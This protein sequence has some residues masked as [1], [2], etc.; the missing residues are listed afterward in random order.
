MVESQELFLKLR[1]EREGG[2]GNVVSVIKHIA[3]QSG[4]EIIENFLLDLG[5][6]T[7]VS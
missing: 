3:K 6:W 4:R 5:T 7:V 2:M 1:G